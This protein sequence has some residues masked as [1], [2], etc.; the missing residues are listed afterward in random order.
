MGYS[1]E[2]IETMKEEELKKLIEKEEKMKLSE[3]AQTIIKKNKASSDELE[4]LRR[5]LRE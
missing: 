2:E 5:K 3:A 4:L 1:K